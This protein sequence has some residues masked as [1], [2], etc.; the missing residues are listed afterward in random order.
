MESVE[1]SEIS[2]GV[3]NLE[4]EPIRDITTLAKLVYAVVNPPAYEAKEHP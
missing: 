3:L 1:L 4:V 2:I